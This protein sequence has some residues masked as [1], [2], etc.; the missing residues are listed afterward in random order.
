MFR[1]I[2]TC[3]TLA[4]LMTASLS[5]PAQAG[6]CSGG[7]G[8][9]YTPRPIYRPV[10]RP[11]VTPKVIVKKPAPPAPPKQ[12]PAPPLPQ[13]VSGSRLY[14]DG[15]NFG[16]GEGSVMMKVGPLTMNVEVLSWN[17]AAVEV[18]MPKMALDLALPA[19]LK[20]LRADGSL[21]V[22]KEVQL[23]PEAPRLALGL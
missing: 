11:V 17:A 18:Q 9:H 20:I 2:L 6:G 1:S 8:G 15:K 23:T 7:G 3:S 22:V 5:A 13:V 4:V 10:V 19:K 12:L 14:L 16:G 21:V